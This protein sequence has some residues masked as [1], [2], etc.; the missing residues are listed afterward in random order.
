MTAALPG[1][2]RI[3]VDALLGL[4]A[5]LA[6][7]AL[8]LTLGADFNYDL[9]HYH[10]YN[11]YALVHGRLEYWQGGSHPDLELIGRWHWES[12][13]ASHRSAGPKHLSQQLL[14]VALLEVASGL[15]DR[16]ADIRPG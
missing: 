16:P 14:L 4:G 5:P 12:Q 3:S 15:C 10:F 7:G 1:P 8:A 2:A 13:G 6:A 9:R 11:G